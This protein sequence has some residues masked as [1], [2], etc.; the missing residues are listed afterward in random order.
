MFLASNSSNYIKNVILDNI[1]MYAEY[2]EEETIY[3]GIF[4]SE[5]NTTLF[6]NVKL[7]NS[8]I[9]IDPYKVNTYVGGL[10][11][12]AKGKTEV[13]LSNIKINVSV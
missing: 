3:A 12:I 10:I 1:S 11:G 7:I 6:E 13:T 2:Y 8:E 4:F 5:A 9:N